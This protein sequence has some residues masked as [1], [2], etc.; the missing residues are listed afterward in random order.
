LKK[1]KFSFVFRNGSSTFESKTTFLH[2][3]NRETPMPAPNCCSTE[4]HCEGFHHEP[5]RKTTI[6]NNYGTEQMKKR[7]AEKQKFGTYL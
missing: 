2:E 6:A 5:K 4:I 7:S 3:Q 1:N